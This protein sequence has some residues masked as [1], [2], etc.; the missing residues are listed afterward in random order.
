MIRTIDLHFRHYAETSLLRGSLTGYD[1]AIFRMSAIVSDDPY[2]Y[3]P[4]VERYQVRWSGTEAKLE[5]GWTFEAS[6]APRAKFEEWAQPDVAFRDAVVW[7]DRS[8]LA[9]ERG[10]FTYQPYLETTEFIPEMETLAIVSVDAT[11]DQLLVT[12]EER[13]A[14]FDGTTWHHYE[15][16]S[17]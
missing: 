2:V 11:E 13:F 15:F 16:F 10:L 14:L 9:T 5:S 1:Q 3:A 12:A 8:W 7:R 6:R 4:R 17:G